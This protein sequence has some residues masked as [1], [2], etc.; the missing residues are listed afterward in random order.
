M[1]ISFRAR[2]MNLIVL[3]R[4]TQ[5]CTCFI[6]NPYHRST[7][8]QRLRWTVFPHGAG[9]VYGK[10]VPSLSGKKTAK[11]SLAREQEVGQ[12]QNAQNAERY[13]VRLLVVICDERP[14]ADRSP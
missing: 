13:F 8:I 14:L 5:R 12:V 4:L 2:W 9:R 3:Q 1:P 11:P 10:V 7:L 6:E